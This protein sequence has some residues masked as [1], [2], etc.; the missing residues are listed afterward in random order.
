MI[1]PAVRLKVPPVKPS[2]P[3]AAT[4]IGWLLVPPPPK[5]RVPLLVLTVPVLL[6]VKFTLVVRVPADL[7]NVPALLKVALPPK[8]RLMGA[9]P[10]MSKVALAV[11]WKMALPPVRIG[12]L[13]LQTRAAVLVR[14]RPELKSCRSAPVMLM[15][16]LAVT[17]A[18]PLKP[19]LDQLSGPLRVRSAEPLMV[20][21]PRLT[22][23]GRVEA[24]LKL[25]VPASNSLMPVRL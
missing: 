25:M 8:S 24:T 5:A 4:F 16:P 23:A 15:P 7:V 14:V 18:G 20:A 9:L 2:V 1:E 11:L 3:A 22:T 19:P 6:K 13:P 17:V 21:P 12:P 10:L